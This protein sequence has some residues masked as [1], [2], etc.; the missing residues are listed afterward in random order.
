MS[1]FD[2]VETA[3]ESACAKDRALEDTRSAIR[4]VLEAAQTAGDAA[5]DAALARLSTAIAQANDL[6]HAAATAL[7]CGALVEEGASPTIALSAILERLPRTFGDALHFVEACRE[8]DDANEGDERNCIER[9]GAHISTEMPSEARAFRSLENLC[10]PAVAM[11]SRSKDA[12]KS[13][14]NR[15]SLLSLAAPLRDWSSAVHFFA[16]MLEVLDD[17]PLIALH[18]RTRRGYA[19][20]ISGIADGFQLHTLLADALLGDP[21]N[22]L[23]EGTRPDPLVVATAKGEPTLFAP[24]PAN[25]TFNLVQWYGLGREDDSATWFYNEAIPGDLAHF[26]GVRTVLLADPPYERSWNADRVFSGMQAE[27]VVV[28]MLSPDDVAARLRRMAAAEREED[29]SE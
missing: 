13:L 5:R 23:L 7:A 10:L 20:S 25:G 11:L 3:V 26:E 19:L 8:D 16:M 1:F 21:A 22:G 4:A 29:D 6:E 17:E 2:L 27:A 18:P 9:C 24:P 12:R 28:E 14:A 15:E